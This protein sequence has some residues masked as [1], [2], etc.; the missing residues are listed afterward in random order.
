MTW[1]KGEK[2]EKRGQDS[3]EW[4]SIEL[5]SAF[6]KMTAIFE[7]QLTTHKCIVLRPASF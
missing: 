4:C 2:G 6:D 5:S 3:D 7:L 1:K